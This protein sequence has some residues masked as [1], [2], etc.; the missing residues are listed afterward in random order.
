[1]RK[2]LLTVLETGYDLALAHRDWLTRLG[3]L[4]A[5][6]L[7]LEAVNVVCF[8]LD[9]PS[10]LPE[11]VNVGPTPSVAPM[12]I[13]TAVSLSPDVPA[14]LNGLRRIGFF[15][16][17]QVV[18]PGTRN[19]QFIE[20]ML[21]GVGQSDA[22]VVLAHDGA[23]TLAF[24]HFGAAKKVEDPRQVRRWT[25]VATHL[26]ASARLRRNIGRLPYP[27]DVAA[28]V[29]EP[30]G[31]LLDANCASTPTLRERL[32]FAVRQIDEARCR[33]AHGARSTKPVARP[34]RRALVSGGSL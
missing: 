17:A 9:S 33:Q 6:Q 10:P 25:A 18:G 34:R 14:V 23:Q 16:G 30:A 1:M 5:E 29:L 31:R 28:A 8:P 21:R 20:S 2:D 24:S 27:P 15:T 12:L 32:R 13:R 7:Q 11:M 22:A 3:T 26:A 19:W 4:V